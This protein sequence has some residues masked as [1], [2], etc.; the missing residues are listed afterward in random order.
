MRRKQGKKKKKGRELRG[1][2]LRIFE[3]IPIKSL[4]FDERKD[5][6]F[7]Q[8]SGQQKLTSET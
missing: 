8:I 7:Q 5:D 3:R 2:D 6:T 1:N 4:Y